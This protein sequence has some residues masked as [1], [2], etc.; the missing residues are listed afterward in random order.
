MAKIL[1]ISS[2]TFNGANDAM[3]KEALMGA[4]ET[5][6]EIEFINL[7][8]KVEIKPCTG[9]IA[10]VKAMMGGKGR[11]CVQKDDFM[12]LLN[13]MLDADGIIMASPIFE[14]GV[15]GI[16]HTICDRFGPSMDRGNLFIA[17]KLSKEHGG[18]GVDPRLLKDKVISFIGVGG[19]DWGTLVQLGHGVLAMSPM[20]K[21]IDNDRFQWSKTILMD[22]AALA[23]AHQI[24]VNLGNAAND[25]P[26]AKWQGPEGVCPH[27]HMNNFYIEPGT[28]HAICCLCGMEG[29]L[30]VH[31][32][33]LTINYPEEQYALAH[34]TLS[35]KL[36]HGQDIQYNEGRLA[37]L[38]KNSPEFKERK[39]KYAK[40]IQPSV[41][42]RA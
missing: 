26:N 12:W 31:D 32:G 1:G 11:I 34:D 4:Q 17:D 6:A 27:C 14:M 15:P 40:F 24:G 23:R 8:H 41:P 37:E 18:P 19:S 13:K 35:G 5:G 2:G 38:Q 30:E 28:T 9:C 22:D 29:E 16:I 25:I 36:K 3:C 39:E 33:K 20:W 7:H 10:C 21:I 42:D